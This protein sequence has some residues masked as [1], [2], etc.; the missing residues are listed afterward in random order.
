MN[1]R[2]F[3]STRIARPTYV[4]F[5]PVVLVAIFFISCPP[6]P[7][8]GGFNYYYLD[9]RAD[10][11]LVLEFEAWGG[12]A[13]R[14]WPVRFTRTARL[15]LPRVVGLVLRRVQIF[16]RSRFMSG[17][18]PSSARFIGKIRLATIF[19]RSKKSEMMTGI[20][21]FTLQTRTLIC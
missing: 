3:G 10:F 7:D 17:K 12:Q 14:A 2:S 6:F 20:L 18:I 13:K 21:F 19:G 8:P 16:P 5:F 9:N 1:L 11:N 15:C 4:S